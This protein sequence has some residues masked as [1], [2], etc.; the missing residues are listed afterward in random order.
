MYTRQYLPL[1]EVLAKKYMRFFIGVVVLLWIAVGS[2]YL[3]TKLFAKEGDIMEAFIATNTGLMES[4]LEMTAEYSNQYMTIKEKEDLIDY[5]A[6]GLGIQTRKEFREN[7]TENRQEVVF[8]K[9][10]QRASTVIKLVT[11]GGSESVDAFAQAQEQNKITQYLIVRIKIYEDA[12]NDILYYQDQIESLYH[13][14]E[15]AK[16]NVHTTL[17]LCGNY[18]GDLLMATKDKISKD[19]IHALEGRIVYENKDED[20]YTVYAYTGLLDEYITLEHSKIN[21]QVAISYD[22]EIDCTKV[23][24]AT[25]IITQDW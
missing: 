2:Q 12:N 21:I 10:A 22:E 5:I 25:P 19:M 4:T 15:I 17:Q 11:I 20:L 9:Q 3:A 8:E 1:K 13:S 16:G 24:L 6:R 14:A 18:A 7:T 23:Y